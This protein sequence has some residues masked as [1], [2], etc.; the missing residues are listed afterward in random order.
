MISLFNLQEAGLAVA[1]LV[2]LGLMCAMCL[3]CRKRQRII[4]EENIIY[5]HKLVRGGQRFTV[6]RSRTVRLTEAPK[7]VPP[8][9]RQCPEVIFATPEDGENQA[10]YQN[11]PSSDFDSLYVNPIPGAVYQNTR[12]DGEKDEDTYSYENVF[13]TLPTAI[14]QDSPSSDYENTSFLEEIKDLEDEP[15]YVNTQ[16]DENKT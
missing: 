1:S 9:Q 5:G 8:T 6:L 14:N 13:P 10:K 4:R 11:L 7:D 3:S 12:A 16:D 2:S 15:D